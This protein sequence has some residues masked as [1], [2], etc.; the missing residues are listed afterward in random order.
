MRY[1]NGGI[2]TMITMVIT[3]MCTTEMDT[4][5]MDTRGMNAIRIFSASEEP[6][7]AKIWDSNRVQ[8]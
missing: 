6:N 7:V 3:A 5:A 8:T 2:K 1:Y 4:T